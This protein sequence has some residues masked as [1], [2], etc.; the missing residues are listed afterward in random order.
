MLTKYKV[1]LVDLFDTVVLRKVHTRKLMYYWATEL[2]KY[3]TIDLLP[4]DIVKKRLDAYEIL[5]NKYEDTGYNDFIE[6]LYSNLC[7]EGIIKNTTCEEFYCVS[8]YLEIK[9][10]GQSHF[11][12]KKMV[13]WLRK[14][15]SIGLKIYCVSD[16]YL[17]KQDILK[18]LQRLNIEDIFDDIFVSCDWN[19]AKRTGNLYKTVL[20]E[21]NCHASDCIMVGCNKFS[22]KANAEIK[23]INTKFIPNYIQHMK[24]RIS[25]ISDDKKLRKKT[26]KRL[27][28][29]YA[30]TESPFSEF[31]VLF[32]VFIVKL[33]NQVL[34]DNIKNLI[35]LSREGLFLKKMF[36]FF[37][38][39]NIPPEKRI[40]T[41]YI[42]V[43]RKSLSNISLDLVKNPLP[44]ID[45][46]SAFLDSIDI[47][48]NVVKQLPEM[49]KFD[50]QNKIEDFS[51]SIEYKTL[52]S[53]DEFIRLCA[54]AHAENT[55]AF[56]K[57]INNYPDESVA[58]V[59]IGWSGTMQ[60]AL[61]S[62]LGKQTLGYYFGIS[63]RDFNDP[64]LYSDK[65][66][67]KG[68]M[69]SNYPTKSKYFDCF[70]GNM[71]VYELFLN[72]PHGGAVSY[73]IINNEVSVKTEW[74]SDDQYLFYNF[75]EPFQN[76]IWPL[77][78]EIC[79]SLTG[80][81]YDDI[82]E[83]VIW[84]MTM[85]S[86][87]LPSKAAVEFEHNAYRYYYNNFEGHDKGVNILSKSNIKKVFNDSQEP[88][89]IDILKRP[90]KYVRIINKLPIY[91]YSKKIGWITPLL[92]YPFYLYL[93]IFTHINARKQVNL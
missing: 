81:L 82:D 50:F 7:N 37:Q 60:K 14:Q 63:V 26:M 10:E 58:F 45:S 17:P 55:E 22:D 92:T 80:C 25:M 20:T 35:F 91:L 19:A 28:K 48:E 31:V 75:A 74:I 78:K 93:K 42:K 21:I 52:V 71:P 33:Y 67:M 30:N 1:I 41:Y 11:I 43:S 68:L 49:I 40:S 69:F 4:Q 89:I 8:H 39:C 86:F 79:N 54:N 76:K 24:N 2:Q 53:N 13:D 88:L 38:E 87:L 51:T 83:N 46:L 61:T 56:K 34:K 3:F 59:D 9:Y 73:S 64:Y 85:H 65:V 66:I 77:F 44:S 18:F 47:P 16:F 29:K 72:A 62:Y 6:L 5:M 27:I 70:A 57:Y 23:L 90:Y 84:D 15:K 36:D 12:N 32:F